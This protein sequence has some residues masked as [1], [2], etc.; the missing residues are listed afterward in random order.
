MQGLM[1][2]SE[3]KDKYDYVRAVLTVMLREATG[4]Q[5]Y[6]ADYYI[7]PN[8]KEMIEISFENEYSISKIDVTGCR[9][10]ELTL[11]VIKAIK[12]G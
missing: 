3:Q 9:K 10:L 2:D 11:L 8:G 6:R 5:H 7:M 4:N 12:E 1:M